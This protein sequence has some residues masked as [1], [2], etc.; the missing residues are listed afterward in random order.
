VTARDDDFLS[1]LELLLELERQEEWARFRA[2]RDEL[3]PQE[4]AARGWAWLDLAAVDETWGLGGR[5]LVALEREGGRPIE[6]RIDAGDLVELRPRR[7]EVEEPARGVVARRSRSRVTVAFDRPPPPFVSEGRLSVELLPSDVTYERARA[8]LREL[9]GLTGAATRRREV[10]LGQTAPRP[11]RALPFSP[12]RP[13]NPEQMEAA[14]LALGAEELFLVHGPPGTGKS[15]VLVEIAVQAVR[16]GKRLLCTAPSNAAVDHLLELLLD[17]GLDA[18]RIGHPA[19]V[20]E[21]L[22]AYTLDARVEAHADDLLAREL[23]DEA[24]ELLG[25]A[26]RQRSRGRS[27]ERFSN[28]REAQAEARR[29][30]GE[31]RQL[32]R[33]AVRAVLG[34]ARVVCATLAGIPSSELAEE[35]FDLALVD[36]ATQATEP[37]T[38][39]AWLRAPR[40]VL[41]GDHCQLPP[42]IRSREAEAGGLGVSLFERLLRDHG[43]HPALAPQAPQVPQTAALSRMLREQHRMHEQI[44]AFPSE[45]MYGGALRAHPAAAGRRL[46]EL[47]GPEHAIDDTPVLFLD[48][49]GKGFDDEVAPGTES[50]RNPGEAELVIARLSQLLA[51]GLLP[52]DV[53]VIAPYSAQVQLLRQQAAA[54]G[55]PEVEIDTVDAFQGREKEAIL[56]SLTRSNAA[57][58]L[59]FLTDLRRINVALTRARRHLFLAGDS[60]TLAAHPFYARLVARIQGD[61]GYRSAWEWEGANE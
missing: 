17:A 35:R 31:A 60:A 61:G 50:H 1:H 29:L 51:A 18:L 38:L 39:T 58:E 11:G 8:A 20:A 43:G 10:L 23:F 6:G 55:L 24:H 14:S 45:E 27:R 3:S 15:T 12:T 16:Q 32:E 21:R 48:T 53:A 4:R 19:R 46:G 28:A 25:Y 52:D 49:A 5:L 47:L 56:V 59:G 13:L 41:A 36:E 33:H 22:A 54:R 44:M 42:T 30:L 57:G 26:R 37:M 2:L 9:R 40:V 7:A 34:G